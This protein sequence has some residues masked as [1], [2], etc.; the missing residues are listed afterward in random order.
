VA[1]QAAKMQGG[2]DPRNRLSALLSLRLWQRLLPWLAAVV[3]VSGT[4][5]ATALWLR[6]DRG[7][8]EGQARET[9]GQQALLL[10]EQ[11]RGVLSRVDLIFDVLDAWLLAHPQARLDHPDLGRL[12]WQLHQGGGLGFRVQI[13]D[14]D[15]LLR[16]SPFR[17]EDVVRLVD[18]LQL[19]TADLTRLS[20][21]AVRL[22]GA[23]LQSLETGRVVLPVLR[24]PAVRHPELR[25]WVVTV[26]VDELARVFA[27]ANPWPQGIAVMARLDGTVLVMSPWLPEWLGR[28]VA[29]GDLFTKQLWRAPTGSLFIPRSYISGLP[30]MVGYRALADEGLLV[31]SSRAESEYLAPYYKDRILAW[32]SASLVVLLVGVYLLGWLRVQRR[33]DANVRA[34][35]RER[36]RLLDAQ[37]LARLGFWELDLKRDELTASPLA[38]ELLQLTPDA[39]GRIPAAR[40]QLCRRV[41]PDDRATVLGRFEAP[42]GTPR[43]SEYR[44]L[45]PDGQTRWVQERTLL[46]AD[47]SGSPVRVLGTL[48]DGTA[49]V[50]SR[51]AL[52]LA[53]SVFEHA[54]EGVMVTDA[55]ARII[56]VNQAFTR[57][58]GYS[59]EE[60]IGL[61]P[62]IINSSHYDP[63]FYAQ[64]WKALLSEGY[65]Q[66]EVWNRRKNGELYLQWETIT[67]VRDPNG[68]LRNFIA[69]VADITDLWRKDQDLRHQAEHDVLTDLPNRH[70][71]EDRLMQAL[72]EREVHGGLLA[73]LFIDLDD[74]KLVNDSLGHAA[75][76][77]LLVKVAA[78][79][80]AEIG[81]LA[82]LARWGGDEFVVLSP[83]MDDPEQA[84][85][86]AR[87]LLASLR[88]PLTIDSQVLHVNLSIGIALAPRDGSDAET[89]IKHA[90][91]AMYR[92]KAESRGGMRFFDPE[93]NAQAVRRL[94]LEAQLRE[95]VE[96]QRFE[97]HYQP[98]LCLDTGNIAGVEAL[99]RWRAEDG[100]LI[101]PAEFIP[102][103]EQT[104]L[105][106]PIG[107]WALAEAVRQR[108]LW[109]SE[110]L[111]VGSMAVNLSAQQLRHEGLLKQIEQTLLRFDLPHW[112][113]DLEL[114]ESVL[115]TDAE[116]AVAILQS[117]R[118][119]GIT[120]SVD[121]FGT[122]YSSLAY[123]KRLPINRLKIDRAFVRDLGT[124]AQ[125][126]PIARAVVALATALDLET[127]AEGIETEAQLSYL[128]R[129]GCDQG[130]GYLFARPMP[131]DQLRAWVLRV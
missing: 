53:A 29:G 78:R 84:A 112:E 130:Q 19:G 116:Q 66:G 33:L 121:D 110:D 9:V 41:H 6:A 123:L 115:M 11:V 38:G 79:L 77:R 100:T 10:D 87:R 18:D 90:D 62:R 103:A 25:Y 4:L 102:L 114:T 64:L 37:E 22:I 126:E 122:G 94:S 105:I 73:V 60:A 129:I 17:S 99:I 36:S 13:V 128:R 91:T 113:L 45:L 127:V 5:V 52:R 34:L 88:E 71:F 93:M 95:A 97:L 39:D 85:D 124:D 26:G 83:E 86:L 30:R 3:A 15:G 104:R 58:T 2:F 108:V 54:L 14:S 35:E 24:W 72:R 120:V 106:L 44:W 46:L 47:E 50:Q 12:L 21:A 131:A 119:M 40:A 80:G 74:F 68:E 57:I 55:Q 43:L 101:S 67:A 81:P 16:Q 20:G 7:F 117:L 31:I 32:M 51:D 89:L 98:K 56:S 23:P 82:T 96:Q 1:E 75:G 8:F 92:V 28:S 111:P 61:T 69:V 48:Q 76:D 65:W 70:L 49:E 107:E 63:Q 42:A 125:S 59:A 27:R 109:R 118:E